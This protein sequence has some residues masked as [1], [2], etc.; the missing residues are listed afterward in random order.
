LWEDGLGFCDKEHMHRR[1]HFRLDGVRFGALLVIGFAGCSVP[2]LGWDAGAEDTNRPT[3]E[4]RATISGRVTTEGAGPIAGVHLVTRPH[5]FE[6]TADSDGRFEIRHL[7]MDEYRLL[8]VADGFDP[9]TTAAVDTELDANSQMDITLVASADIHGLITVVALHPN[10]DPLPGAVVTVTT[11]PG[12]SDAVQTVDAVT[13][14]AGQLVVEGFGGTTV[15][16]VVG[17]PDGIMAE[18]VFSGLAVPTIGGTQLTVHLSGVP[19]DDADWVG[20]QYCMACHSSLGIQWLDT[21]HAGTI[22]ADIEGDFEDAFEAGQTL[23]MGASQVTLVDDDGSPLVILTDSSG[24]SRSHVVAGVIGSGG[25]VP[26]VELGSG[27][28]PLPF[29]W[30]PEDEDREPWSDGEGRMVPFNDAVW[31]DAAGAFRFASAESMDP[32]TSAEASCFPCHATGFTITPGD[33]GGVTMAAS[34]GSDA[35]W[36][37]GSVGCERC[38]GPGSDH[39][40]GFGD[41]RIENIVQPNRL[42]FEAGIGVCGQ[43]HGGVQSIDQ[44]FP[45]PYSDAFGLFHSGENLSDYAV[46]EP[47][48]WDVGLA[49]EAHQQADE[50]RESMHTNGAVRL[51]CFDCHTVHAGPS[52]G[53]RSHEDNGHPGSTNLNARDNTLCLSCHTALTFE[54]DTGLAASH[55]QHGEIDPAGDT[56]SGR[57]I[58]CHMP[59]TAGYFGFGGTSGAGD[60]SSHSFEAL[61]PAMTIAAFSSAGE[62]QLDVGEFPAHACLECHQFNAELSDETGTSFSGISGD[63]TLLSTHEAFLFSYEEMFP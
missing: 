20:S 1:P 38:H 39:L 2:E 59:K 24:E 56:E 58:G 9:L 53:R 60:R 5:G 47:V 33:D 54:G 63:P 34:D 15:D 40:S 26:F 4:D 45:F 50:L 12:L 29:A 32:A 36:L 41:E 10:G 62:D 42:G 16:V 23:D 57:C 8:A 35:R 13:D 17:G 52:D 31:F 55:T 51:R 25:H 48:E 6:S 7:P 19:S 3:Q 37:E 14:D 30:S 46:S 28:W 61:S 27:A 43:C 49:A 21:P 11:D 22:S 44:D 18:R